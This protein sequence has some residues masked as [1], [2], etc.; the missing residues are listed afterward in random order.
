MLSPPRP[1]LP[2]FPP[3]R[4]V[5]NILAYCVDRS[6]FFRFFAF[7]HFS[8]PPYAPHARLRN[9]LGPLFPPNPPPFPPPFPPI[10]ITRPFLI[11]FCRLVCLK[12]VPS[13]MKP[14]SFLPQVI[15][16]FYKHFFF[17]FSTSFPVPFPSFPI[18]CPR[19]LLILLS[20]FW[21]E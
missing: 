11:L 1:P 7:T 4:S 16:Y 8:Q 20:G 19:L 14:F 10:L 21:L 17:I 12:I 2:F 9:S 15:I 13:S 5:K 6:S 18:L 3:P